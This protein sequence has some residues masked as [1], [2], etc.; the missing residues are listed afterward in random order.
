[1]AGSCIKCNFRGTYAFGRKVYAARLGSGG[2]P[3]SSGDQFLHNTDDGWKGVSAFSAFLEY[4]DEST[5]IW[6]CMGHGF[7]EFGRQLMNLLQNKN[8][9]KLTQDI[10]EEDGE[11]IG[12]R[13]ADNPPWV[14]CE[15]KIAL[16][17]E[18]LDF[19]LASKVSAPSHRITH[20]TSLPVTL[21]VVLYE[22]LFV[23]YA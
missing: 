2:E 5:S 12:A 18:C 23:K 20:I 21:S 22:S 9:R 8:N 10:C 19:T 3:W 4:F 13:S 14:L 7:K 1:M 15:K 11:R 17:E 6:Y 16:F